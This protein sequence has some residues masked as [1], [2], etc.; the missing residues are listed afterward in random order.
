MA[1]A[2]AML[3][4]SEVILLDEPTLGLDVETSYEVREILKRLF[5]SITGPLLSALMIWMSFKIFVS[6]QSL[7]I[8]E[9]LL[10]MIELKI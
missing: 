1:I 5:E 6:G 3:A 4:D 10:Q 9:K 2:V 7:L 8:K